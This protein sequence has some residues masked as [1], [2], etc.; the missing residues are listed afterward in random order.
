MWA[1]NFIVFFAGMYLTW[2]AVKESSFIDWDRIFKVFKK[3]AGDK[4]RSEE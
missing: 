4:T 2:R 3:L 1:P